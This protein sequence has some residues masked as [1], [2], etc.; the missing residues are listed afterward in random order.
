MT[1]AVQTIM[2][3]VS[4]LSIML[5]STPSLQP[6]KTRGSFPSRG[7]THRLTRPYLRCDRKKLYSTHYKINL[8]PAQNPPSATDAADKKRTIRRNSRR[9]KTN[10]RKKAREHQRTPTTEKSAFNRDN[11]K[12]HPNNPKNTGEKYREKRS[13]AA[14]KFMWICRRSR[15]R[16]HRR[17]R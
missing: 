10:Q 3:A 8:T 12:K 4:P 9:E 5:L 15:Q 14:K 7:I 11:R 17:G 6:P 2:N 16:K 13:D 1:R